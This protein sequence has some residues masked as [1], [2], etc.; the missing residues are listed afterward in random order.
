MFWYVLLLGAALL[1]SLILLRQLLIVRMDERIDR[2]LTQEAAEFQQ[3]SDGVNP[4]TGEPFGEDVD[5]LFRTFFNRS[6]PDRNEVYLALVDGQPTLITASPHFRIDRLDADVVRWGAVDEPLWEK[7]STPAGPVRVLAVPVT[8][9]G[10]A[11]GT[12]VFAL[13]IDPERAEVDT[14]IGAAATVSGGVLVFATLVAWLAAGRILAPLREL[15]RTARSISDSELTARISVRGTDEVANLGRTF[16]E[17]LDRLE[18]AFSLQRRFLDDIGH[19]LATPITIIRGQLEIAGEDPVQRQESLALVLDELDR[20]QRMVDDLLILA[21]AERPDF[22]DLQE[23]DLAEFID[24]VLARATA[25]GQRQWRLDAI[26]EGRFVADRNRLH[27]AVMNLLQNA[28]RYTEPGDVIAVGS[29]I[30]CDE[31]RLWVRDTGPGISPEDQDRIFGRFERGRQ[32]R[33]EGSGLGL[34]IV[35]AIVDAHRGRV[36]LRSEPGVE[37][38]FTITIPPGKEVPT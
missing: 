35:R 30:A 37:T 17:M 18:E 5:A 8:F 12:L 13:F 21:R 24:E 3:L 29:A 14:A 31:V 22:L 32:P 26:G 38:V 7:I 10:E 6:V 11:R 27:Q 15:N 9:E 36:T 20:V 1:A 25:L 23:I 16:N 19:E 34:A 4:E 28:V 33:S 2:A